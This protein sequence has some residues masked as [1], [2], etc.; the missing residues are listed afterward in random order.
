[1]TDAAFPPNYLR[2]KRA[3]RACVRDF[4]PA[5]FVTAMLALSEAW[6]HDDAETIVDANVRLAVYCKIAGD[7]EL[8]RLA[9]RASQLH[10]K[11]KETA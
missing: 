4:S 11:W 7:T 6:D 1:M 8:T 5:S 9:A 10:R 3:L 2:A